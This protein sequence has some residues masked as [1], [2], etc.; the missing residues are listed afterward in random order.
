MQPW[1][2]LQCEA[3][4]YISD[5]GKE[6]I[7]KVLYICADWGIP[8]RGFKGASVHVREFVS[9]LTRGGNEVWLLCTDRGEGNSDPDATVIEIEPRSSQ[10]RREKEAARLGLAF[11]PQD[12]AVCHELDK[13]SYDTEFAARALAELAARGVWAGV[14]CELYSLF[15]AYVGGIVMLSE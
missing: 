15:H 4:S 5:R 11:D 13:L 9:A 10:E 8:I 1:K 3:N 6:G 14:V 7:V 12:V 2:F